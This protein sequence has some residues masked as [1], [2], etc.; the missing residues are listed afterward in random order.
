[1]TQ[2]FVSDLHLNHAG[3][4]KFCNRPYDSV[5]EMNEDLIRRWNCV[6]GQHD[7]V[8][9]LGDF[10][11][12]STTATPV[13]DLFARLNGH[14][15]LVV[16]N[17]D[18]KNPKVLKLPWERVEKLCVVKEGGKKIVVCHYPLESWAGSC[19][20][21][22]HAHGHQHGGGRK[23]PHRFDVGVDVRPFPVSFGDLIAEAVAQPWVP[24]DRHE[25]EER[26]EH[27][28][29]DPCLCGGTQAQRACVMQ[30][31]EYCGISEQRG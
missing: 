15:M 30:G 10:A 5:G 11:F 2:Y 16:G 27:I 13:A 7:L 31:C 22:V 14:K 8:W 23:I 21:T 9:V 6:V 18:E 26:H 1:M 4:I 17:H 28:Q 19:H 20:G 25:I 12:S 3:V 29:L 24:K